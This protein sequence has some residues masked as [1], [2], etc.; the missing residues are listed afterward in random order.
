M[1][2]L[3]VHRPT[4]HSTVRKALPP[5][6]AARANKPSGRPAAPAKASKPA[7][8][9]PR[10]RLAP[11]KARAGSSASEVAPTPFAD[12]I[13]RELR[14]IRA[15]VAPRD[16]RPSGEDGGLGSAVDSMRRL[17]SELL[18][19]DHDA[20][21]RELVPIRLAVADPQRLD[22]AAALRQI[23]RLMDR[24]GAIQFSA[25]KLDYVDPAIHEIKGERHVVGLPDGVVAES[26]RPGFRSA[27]GVVLTKAWVAVNRRPADESS[28]D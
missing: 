6:T 7:G 20:V 5:R 10:R 24:L 9:K 25:Q 27:S 21:L 3:K 14:A 1:K 11:V 18:E 13:L 19:R 8:S 15:A 28:R 22:L 4:R 2:L 23:D 16:H 12:D 26:L 17:L